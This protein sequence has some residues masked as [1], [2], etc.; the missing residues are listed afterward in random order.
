MKKPNR[1]GQNGKGFT[2]TLYHGS[3][4]SDIESFDDN[5]MGRNT[6]SGEKFI[7]FT[8]DLAFADEFSYERLETRSAYINA[9][10][11]KGSVYEADVTM[12]KPLD[13]NNLTNKDVSNILK[14]TDD[15]LLTADEVKR[16]AKN[17]NHQLLKT[18]FDLNDIKKFG[19]DGF[20]AKVSKR[21][22]AL[23]Y[24]VLSSKQIKN[25]KKHKQG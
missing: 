15:D 23:E 4:S 17:G 21:S 19:Y 7:Y 25:N 12:K 22:N 16:Y 10:G 6:S 3:P 2:K 24:G 11:A 8:D 5:H 1:G 14:L 18:Y 9:K 20:I 13:F